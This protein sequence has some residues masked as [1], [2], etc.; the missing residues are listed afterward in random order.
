MTKIREKSQYVLGAFLV[1]FLLSMTVGGLIGGANIMDLI[2]GKFYFLKG[3]DHPQHLSRYAGYVGDEWI[4]RQ[5]FERER[6]IQINFQ[7]NNRGIDLDGQAILSAENSAWN[8][9]VDEAIQKPLIEKL[10]LKVSED[11]LFEYILGAPADLQQYFISQG[12]FVD[13]D[14]NFLLS[15]YQDAVRSGNFPLL[16]DQRLNYETNVRR[17]LPAKKLQEIFAATASINDLEVR[18]NYIDKNI[19]CIIEFA[20]INSN[21][22]AD[23]LIEITDSEI[24]KQYNEDKE[25]SYKIYPSRSVEYIYWNIDYTGVDSL[26]HTEHKDSIMQI[27]YAVLDSSS[28]ETSLK[29]GVSAVGGELDTMDLT[30]EYDN[31]SGVPYRLGA[32]RNLVRFAFDNPIGTISDIMQVKDGHVICQVVGAN[33]GG[34]KSLDEVKA[35]IESKLIRDKKLEYAKSLLLEA[36]ENALST[37]DIASNNDLINFETE[38]SGTIGSSFKG[39][40]SSSALKGT[41]KAM[42]PGETSGIVDVS[43]NAVVI[44]MIEKDEIVEDDFNAA[45][46]ELRKELLDGKRY[47]KYNDRIYGYPPFNEYLTGVK[48][49]TPVVDYR[50]KIY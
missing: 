18:N 33:E 16:E 8:R 31:L 45:L 40:G 25:D 5:A 27:S 42:S 50:S 28:F 15:D 4:E 20:Y 23:S 24:E 12:L 48:E 19:N 30:L 41:L 36:Q 39:I 32:S 34:F 38:V 44:S 6:S 29:E 47:S 2:I 21:S 10:G 37:A 43:Y 22:I 1:I 49:N 26:Y 11:E 35:S 3:D 13:E 14:N 9:L 7:R 46:G 17:I